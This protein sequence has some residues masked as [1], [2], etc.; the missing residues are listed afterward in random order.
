MNTNTLQ[1]QIFSVIAQITGHDV[2]E[3]EPDMY[4]E[5]DLGLDSIKIME[6]LNGLIQIIPEEQQPL[7]MEELP[8]QKLIQLQTLG[9]VVTATENCLSSQ[10]DNSQEITTQEQAETEKVEIIH[11]QYFHLLGHWV[12][13]SI[14]LF[15]TLRLRG[16]FDNNIAWQ[17]WK[18]LLY[19]HPMLRSR[20]IIPLNATRFKDYEI[21]VLNNSNPPEI[22]VTDIR[23]LD[24][25]TQ[26]QTINEEL[27]RCLNYEW[28]ITQFPLHQF[29][30]FR[31]QDSL[32][33]L[34]LANEHL[35]SDALGCHTILREFME[36]YHAHV[37]NEQP[38]LPPATTVAEYQQMVQSINAWQDTESEKALVEYTNRQ[39]TDSYLWNP[40]NKKITS[41]CPVFH[42]RRYALS[43][44][45]TAALISQTR[46][47]RLPINSLLLAALVRTIAKLEQSDNK[48]IL[49]QVPTSGRFYP[50]A[51]ATNVVGSFAQNLSIDIEL[52]SA[53]EN[54]ETLLNQI[55]QKVQQGIANNR[56]RTQTR[57]MGIAFRDNIVL[58]N[59]KIPTRML[60]MYRQ[61]LKS[62]LYCP[63]TGQT[64]IKKQYGN[65]E[66]IDYRAGG[67]NAPGTIDILQEIFDDCLQL[68]A[69][70]DSDFFPLAV[71]DQLMEEYRDQIE[72][73]IALKTPSQQLS[74]QLTQTST[75]G[76]VKSTLQEIV[77]QVSHNSINECD[78]D[79]DMESE[80]GV[81]SLENIRIITKLEKK[82]GKVNRQALLNCRTLREMAVVLSNR[83]SLLSIVVRKL[84]P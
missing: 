78:M 3:L 24:S 1:Q 47:W 53:T 81:D 11:G 8:L 7:F 46:E 27:H 73:L 21:E 16:N 59:G 69:S 48:S 14:S 13:N 84:K 70:Y 19:R 15:S 25:E 12:V 61:V 67:I 76:D 4:L 77:A 35:I 20:F 50:E 6:F 17:T 66:V 83:Q 51:D 32:Y 26:E 52:P 22:P 28:Q 41:G 37:N 44:A 42:N 79:K 64:Q 45:T 18:D 82:L 40:A 62:N 57:Q 31:L 75:D 34:I 38:N 74:K 9:E 54:W 29:F 30:V 23:H 72:A 65:L 56:D 55:H 39:G 60:P 10:Q 71:V 36:I 5:G 80:L 58:E 63:F 43:H 49:L 2:E 33:Q 68:Q